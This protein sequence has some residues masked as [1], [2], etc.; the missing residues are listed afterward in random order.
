MSSYWNF[1]MVC[2]AAGAFVIGII[3]TVFGLW[4]WGI[5][6]ISLG[7]LCTWLVWR[8]ASKGSKISKNS[9]LKKEADGQFFKLRRE[10]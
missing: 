8:K 6:F 9:V 3:M 2:D 4:I 10:F 7:I 5:V 1:R